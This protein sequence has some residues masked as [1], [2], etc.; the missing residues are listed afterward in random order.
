[1]FLP[2]LAASSL[3]AA[4][5]PLGATISRCPAPL[6]SSCWA[7]AAAAW[8]VSREMSTPAMAMTLPFCS[9]GT[10]MLVISTCLPPTVSE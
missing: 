1:M 9:S 4:S 10:V 2:T 6:N 7:L 3:L 5:S 8:S